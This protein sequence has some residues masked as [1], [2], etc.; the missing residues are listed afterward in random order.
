[1]R[2]FVLAVMALVVSGSAFGIGGRWRNNNNNN[3]NHNSGQAVA[4][5]QVVA[6]PVQQSRPAAPA[7]AN[8]DSRIVSKNPLIVKGSVV[9]AVTPE[10]PAQA[11]DS[12]V[13]SKLPL[14]AKD[15]PKVM[16]GKGEMVAWVSAMCPNP[17]GVKLTA[18]EIGVI[19]G[20][21]RTRARVGLKPVHP[22][23]EMMDL[24]R[25]KAKTLAKHNQMNHD[26][27]PSYAHIVKK[28]KGA[29]RENAG[30]NYA[31]AEQ[32]VAGWVGSGGHYAAMVDAQCT[33]IGAGVALASNGQ[34]YWI[35]MLH[36]DGPAKQPN[37]KP[38]ADV[39][40]PGEKK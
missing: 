16:P 19:E 1:M 28:G 12:R 25:I 21:N 10:K 34:P 38:W 26:L 20:T 17:Q 31:N 13:V 37:G 4:R 39:L 6:P 3:N 14:M 27:Y 18:A 33:Q 24:A 5:P 36:V 8:S 35:E 9:P 2:I 15:D 22:D 7:A 40:Y 11:N 23:Q 29:A 32:A 30:W